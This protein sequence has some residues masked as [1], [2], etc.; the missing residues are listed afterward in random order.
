VGIIR[1]LLKT[2]FGKHPHFVR[3]F[4]GDPSTFCLKL[5]LGPIHISFETFFGNHPHFVRNFLCDPSIFEKHLHIHFV[6]NLYSEPSAFCYELS[7][8]TNRIS[9]GTFFSLHPGN[10]R[11]VRPLD[12]LTAT[13]RCH[14][15]R[16]HVTLCHVAWDDA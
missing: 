9:L 16:R 6:R 2:F 13:P 11:D 12:L 1:N 8:G 15:T 4:L 10:I 3:N 14:M 7:L 5:S